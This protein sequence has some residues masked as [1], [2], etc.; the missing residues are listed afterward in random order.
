MLRLLGFGLWMGIKKNWDVFQKGVWGQEGGGEE[1]GLKEQAFLGVSRPEKPM[2]Y[3]VSTPLFL[4][5]AHFCQGL[6]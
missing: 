4:W 5:L 1:G 6:S 2:W 3:A